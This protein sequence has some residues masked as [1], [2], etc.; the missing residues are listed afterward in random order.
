[1]GYV[2]QVDH[3]LTIGGLIA[4]VDVHS[5]VAGV[6]LLREGL[7]G[8]RSRFHV[9]ALAWGTAD[10]KQP[11]RD[12]GGK[13][14][15]NGHG[16]GSVGTQSLLGS[17]PVTVLNGTIAGAADQDF[18]PI[19]LTRGERLQGSL[20]NERNGQAGNMTLT[21]FDTDGTTIILQTGLGAASGNDPGVDFTAPATGTYFLR[22]REGAGTLGN[23]TYRLELW[24]R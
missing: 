17:S 12:V 14:D 3:Y 4:L 5:E 9:D 11:G 22:V 1:M 19:A 20:F 2:A 15:G 13:I 23:N 6:V 10:A 21:V 16:V 18:Y 8:R 7:N 24:R